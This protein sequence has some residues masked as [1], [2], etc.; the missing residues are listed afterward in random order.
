MTE[1]IPLPVMI[2]QHQD[3]T[4]GAEYWVQMWSP[5][6]EDPPKTVPY[7]QRTL[8]RLK[9]MHVWDTTP[10]VLNF[11]LVDLHRPNDESKMSWVGSDWADL[12]AA[13]HE[14]GMLF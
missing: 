13:H 8:M 2:P 3:Y 12:T 1:R 14:L 11:W 4:I 10:D 9:G 7:G 5:M 6:M